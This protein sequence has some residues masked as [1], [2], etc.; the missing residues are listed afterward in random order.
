[1]EIPPVAFVAVYGSIRRTDRTVLERTLSPFL[2]ENA[3]IFGDLNAISFLSDASNLSAGYA[4][5]LVWP[6][7]TQLE[8]KEMVIDTVRHLS[9]G[10]PPKTR[11]RGHNGES[12][13]DRILLTRSLFRTATP[14]AFSVSPLLVAGAVASD[15]D[16]VLLTLLPWGWD[17]QRPRLCQG[18]SKKHIRL[19]QRIMTSD[20]S[21]STLPFDSI[22]APEQIVAWALLGT[23]MLK[24]LEVVNQTYPVRPRQ[25]ETGWAQHV[26][27][28][29]RLARRNHSCF[30]R[31][32]RHDLLLPMLKPRL[33]FDPKALMKLVQTSN[34]WDPAFIES[35]PS[36]PKHPS[37]PLPTDE[38][39]RKLSRIPRA[40]SPI[41]P[42]LLYILP[43]H[44]FHWIASGIR[45]SLQL[46]HLLPHFLNS[47]L[48]GIFK[49][50]DR[51]WEP[52]SWRPIC[53]ATASYR[54]GARYLK[55]FLL[56]CIRPHIHPHQY[57]AL[58]Q[59]PSIT[60]PFM[61]N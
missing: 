18:W 19:F 12:Y 27:S 56:R 52:S 33:P 37:I 21:P 24:A 22:P 26:R 41:P 15:H 28:L 51:W 53:M 30:F 54:I 47:V 25:Q 31:R 7:L 35:L 55:S 58:P 42:Y 3:V 11:L 2:R 9:D 29:L 45:I 20:P 4:Q 39:L 16:M 43:E 60:N 1:M 49:N 17:I 5:S 8:E 34:P 40:K 23:Q 48:V 57:G 32:V 14:S 10:N 36:H 46:Q 50:K 61:A 13:L 59:R 38:E 6:W 44:L